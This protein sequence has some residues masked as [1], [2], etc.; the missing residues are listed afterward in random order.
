M[1]NRV[2]MHH[3]GRGLVDTP[4]DFGLRSEPPTHPELLDWLAARFVEGGWSVKGLHRLILLSNA[5]Q[6]ASDD[7]PEARAVD[8]ENLLVWR[9]NRRRLE[10]EAMR[11]AILAVAG[12]LDAT[13]G[14]RPVSITAEPFSTRRTVY[15]V[16]RPPEPRRPVP[17]LR[18]RQPRRLEPRRG[19]RPSCRSRPCS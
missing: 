9:Q 3:F 11:D 10:F 4:S 1:V 8:P 16:H 7:R 2:W 13:I 12:R 15:G 5:Y 6:Q 17:H 18:L 19:T 14:G